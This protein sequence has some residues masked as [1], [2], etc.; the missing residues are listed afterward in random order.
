MTRKDAA[1]ACP[2]RLLTGPDKEPESAAFCVSIGPSICDSGL[3]FSKAG[4]KKP[5]HEHDIAKIRING[6]LATSREATE[7]RQIGRFS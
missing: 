1:R 2:P 6:L 5:L 3:I 7:F 4:G